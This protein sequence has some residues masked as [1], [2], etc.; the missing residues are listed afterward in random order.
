LYLT[1][2]LGDKMLR[3]FSSKQSARL[4]EATGENIIYVQKQFVEIDCCS[5]IIFFI[6]RNQISIR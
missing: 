3:V 2:I 1:N 6:S 4:I 5:Y